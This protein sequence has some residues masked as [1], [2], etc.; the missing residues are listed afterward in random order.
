MRKLIL[1]VCC[2]ITSTF[3][4]LNYINAG[5]ALLIGMGLSLLLTNPYAAFCRKQSSLVLKVAI[6]GMGFGLSLTTV[7]TTAIDTAVITFISIALALV[8]GTGIFKLLK[9]PQKTSILISSG[10]AICGGSAIA[11][12]SPVIRA[13]HEQTAMAVTVVFLL[14]IVALYVFP[15]LGALLQMTQQ[16]FGIW[17]AL[18]IHDTSS[19]V[20][21][22]AT[23]GEEALNIA[24]TTKLARALWIIPL[25]LVMSLIYHRGKKGISFP[26]FIILF[27]LASAV[28]TVLPQFQLI[29]DNVYYLAKQAMVLA[30]FILGLGITPQVFK[31]LDL[32]P[33]IFGIILWILLACSSLFLV[34]YWY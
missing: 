2:L 23:Y 20:G 27:I 10:T 19:V 16:E 22:A 14:N 33:M 9:V 32:R 31:S 28:T 29:Y 3:I 30:L 7:S 13:N 34:F 18:A 4:L 5:V 15:E 1:A 17:A 24:T 6:V 11:A 25:S 26:L 12:V 21:A 8:A